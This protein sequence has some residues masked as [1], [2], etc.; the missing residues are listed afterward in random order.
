MFRLHLARVVVLL[1]GASAFA[2]SERSPVAP[3]PQ[4]L[5]A[6]QPLA[7]QAQSVEGSY[8]LSFRPTGSGLGVILAAYVAQLGSGAPAD[9][10]TAT[11]QFCAVGKAPRPRA[12]CDSGSGHWVRWGSASIIPPPATNAGFALMTYDLAPTSGTTIGFRFRYSGR[13][14]GDNSGI[15]DGVSLSA[16][17]TF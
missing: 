9:S 14:K 8:V 6:S 17:H 7:I 11:F 12:D 15:A 16:D 5:P 2:C 4:A 10:G 3:E 13:S 1:A